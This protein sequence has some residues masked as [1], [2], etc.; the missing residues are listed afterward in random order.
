[1][2]GTNPAV[3]TSGAGQSSNTFSFGQ[4]TAS[5]VQPYDSVAA[6]TNVNRSSGGFGGQV[7]NSKLSDVQANRISGGSVFDYDQL[8]DY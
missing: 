3:Y 8:R 1:M 7:N 2:T 4:N 6:N 5:L